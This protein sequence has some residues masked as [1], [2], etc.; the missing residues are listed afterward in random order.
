MLESEPA[1]EEKEENLK[2]QKNESKQKQRIERSMLK[3][4][5]SKYTEG[6]DS[7]RQAGVTGAASEGIQRITL[8]R[9]MPD[10]NA[11]SPS[12]D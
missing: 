11:R 4:F 2:K 7:V 1:L 10:G 5:D 6:R 8:W 3:M 12:T 9:T